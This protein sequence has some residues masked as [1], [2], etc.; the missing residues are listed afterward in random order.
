MKGKDGKWRY[1]AVR[2]GDEW[3]T[4]DN[5]DNPSWG[6][7]PYLDVD[8]TFTSDIARRFHGEEVMF[9]EHDA[10]ITNIRDVTKKPKCGTCG[11]EDGHYGNCPDRR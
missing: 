1:F 5:P 11:M 7:E 6:D 9:V 10:V 8:R 4:G 2:R 3:W